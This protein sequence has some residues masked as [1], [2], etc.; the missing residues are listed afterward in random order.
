MLQHRPSFELPTPF[1]TGTAMW[2]WGMAGTWPQQHCWGREGSGTP[3]GSVRGAG[4]KDGRAQ[5]SLSRDGEQGQ[6]CPGVPATPL[7]AG[8]PLSGRLRQ[9]SRRGT[10][11][12]GSHRAH[13]GRSRSPVGTTSGLGSGRGQPWSL[14]GTV[15]VAHGAAAPCHSGPWL[16]WCRASCAPVPCRASLRTGPT[17]PGAVPCQPHSPGIAVPCQP[18]CWCRA[19]LARRYLSAVPF[20]LHAGPAPCLSRASLPPGISVPCQP[21][22]P[23]PRGAGMQRSIPGLC[24]RR[25]PRR[26]SRSRLR[27]RIPRAGARRPGHRGQ[28]TALGL[29]WG[30]S[31]I[32]PLPFPSLPPSLPRPRLRTKE[33]RSRSLTCSGRVLRLRGCLR[34]AARAGSPEAGQGAPSR[35]RSCSEGGSAPHPLGSTI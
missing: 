26:R 15:R 22:Q 30:R 21:C 19:S 33:P 3:R 24:R 9:P 35:C 34:L 29:G 27:R 2:V 18:E 11:P 25:C 28:G 14:P 6:V 13:Q 31:G 32:A 20:S 1:Q 17:L 4:G 12:G 7:G 16:C 8:V 5:G 23:C 10:H